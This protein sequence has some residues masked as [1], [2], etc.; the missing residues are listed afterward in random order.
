MA[1][2]LLGL[3]L[4]RGIKLPEIQQASFT[5]IP[6]TEVAVGYHTSIIALAKAGVIN[7]FPDGTFRPQTELTRAQAAALLIR[8]TNIEGLEP[9]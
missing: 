6:E 4:N 1:G 3:A 9:R 8:F 7:G 5:D 2:A